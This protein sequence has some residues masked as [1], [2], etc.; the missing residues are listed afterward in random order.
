MRQ[1]LQLSDEQ[2]NKLNKGYTQSWSQYNQGLSGLDKS[3]AEDQ[4]LQ[5]Q[6]EL[7]GG[8]SRDFSKTL[9]NVFTDKSARQR[10]N[11]MDWQYRGYG[12]FNDPTVQQQ[13][14]LNDE[15]RQTFNKYQNEWNQQLNTW[16]REFG[17]D[18][19][20]VANRF[21]DTNKEL[22][23][24]INSTLT[25]EQ[26]TIWTDLIGKPYDFPADVYL[27]NGAVVHSNLKP[28]VK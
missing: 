12:A 24:R 13:L 10:Y 25:P 23:N 16:Q 4:R 22:Q 9:D 3:L 8:F 1:Q 11:Q 27:Q 26:R 15:Q 20:G 14:K 6:Q 17:N 28:E 18:R 2:F 5:R 7:S 21:R 19:N